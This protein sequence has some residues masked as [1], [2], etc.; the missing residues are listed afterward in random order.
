MKVF[1]KFPENLKILSALVQFFLFLSF[2]I[3]HDLL[4]LF[5]WP[6]SSGLDFFHTPALVLALV[7][8]PFP[9]TA[10]HLGSSCLCIPLTPLCSC[11]HS[12]VLN[13]WHT[14]SDFSPWIRIIW[15]LTPYLGSP[16]CK[17]SPLWGNNERT[18]T[19]TRERSK[20]GNR[21]RAKWVWVIGAAQER[22]WV[23]FTICSSNKKLLDGEV[24]SW[25]LQGHLVERF[26]PLTFVFINYE[27]NVGMGTWP[28]S[29]WVTLG[30]V[31]VP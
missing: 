27:K 14:Q 31:R 19:E 20:K 18:V 11:Y 15:F 9:A 26:Y 28:L 13:S 23:H 1:K 2:F 10:A 3:C 25:A 16:S 6:P 29:D 5:P 30:L 8:P 17:V 21:G 7:I 12:L 4:S 24:I 22:P